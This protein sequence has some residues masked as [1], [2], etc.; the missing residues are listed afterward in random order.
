MSCVSVCVWSHS[1]CFSL[2]LLTHHLHLN[3]WQQARGGE[4]WKQNS[5]IVTVWERPFGEKKRKKK[6]E[7]SVGVRREEEVILWA[8]A[9]RMTGLS[10]EISVKRARELFSCF[11]LFRDI[12]CGILLFSVTELCLLGFSCQQ[13]LQAVPERLTVYLVSSFVIYLN[14]TLT[15]S[16]TLYELSVTKM[17]NLFKIQ[18]F[19]GG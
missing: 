1:L 18:M 7:V 14:G 5:G 12:S 19:L 4:M 3:A 16:V 15:C 11:P 13:D 9:F 8:T 10:W 2:L 6:G 17:E